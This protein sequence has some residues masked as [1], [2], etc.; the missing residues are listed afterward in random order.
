MSRSAHGLRSWSRTEGLGQ[1]APSAVCHKYVESR[2]ASQRSRSCP[3]RSPETMKIG[4]R[5]TVSRSRNRL[6]AP[7]GLR[8]LAGGG[9]HRKPGSSLSPAPAGATDLAPSIY[10][11]ICCPAPL[12]GRGDSFA[13]VPVVTATG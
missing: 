11:P 5:R 13:T 10:C 3:E 4:E 12:P 9:N 2:V 7:E 1:L 6:F 8:I